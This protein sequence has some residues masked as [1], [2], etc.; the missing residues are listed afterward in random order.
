[1]TP[2]TTKLR[3]AIVFALV[4]GAT[5]IAG[6]G[7]AFAQDTPPAPAQP[8]AQE[9][10]TELD[11]IVVTGTRIESQ[12]V[13]S[14]SPV[15]EIQEEA[16]QY[17]G[18][19]KV[20]E[21]VNQYPQLA[22]TFDSFQNN[23]ATGYATVNLRNLGAARTLTLVNGFRLPPGNFEVRDISIVPASVVKRVDILTGG[24]SAV[25][26]SDAI[27]G[28]VNFI[29][30][31]EFE[32]VSLSAGYSAYQHDNSNDYIQG[33]MDEAGFDYPTGDSG[34]GGI[35]R[36]IDFAIG[37]SFADGAG[38]AMAYA[39]WRKNDPLFQGD[40]DYSAC[41]LSGAGTSCG[42]S[43]TNATGN[44]YVFQQDADGDLI[45][46][47]SG[48]LLPDGSFDTA[49]GAP[50]NFAPINYYQRP[51]ERYTFGSSL[52]YEINEHFTPYLQTMFVNKNSSIQVAES[53][54]FF[55][56]LENQDCANPIFGS[57]CSDLGQ[58]PTLPVNIY[59]A[60]RNIEGGP[61]R[62]DTENNTFRFVGGVKGELGEGWAYNAAYIYGS[63]SDDTQGFNDFVN[64]RIE[65]A[66]LG[67]QDDNTF[68]GC[69][70]Y[71]VFEPGGVTPEQAAALAGVSM[72]KTRTTLKSINA[73][74]TGDTGF[75]MPWV[76]GDNVAVVV[77][78]EWREETFDFTADSISQAGDFAG[79]GGASLPLSGKTNVS[80]IFME[81]AVPLL[82]DV[83]FLNSLDMDLGYRL[84]DYT[85]SGQ[86]NTW[87]VGFNADM[88]MVNFRTSYNHAIRAPSI[89]DLFSTQQLA[90]YTVADPCA[91]PTPDFSPE[92]CLNTGV[93]L[94]AYGTVPQNPAN[95]N[96]QL[97]GGNL[98]L[99]PEVGD[100]F[101][102]G[103]VLTPFENAQFN[104][105]Y[106]DIKITDTISTIGAGTIVQYC[107]LSGDPFLCDKVQRN[108]LSYDL[109]RGQEATSGR[110]VNLTD[111]FG[112]VH[113]NGIDFGARYRWDMLGGRFNTSFNGTWKLDETITPLPGLNEDATFDCTGFINTNCRTHEWRHIASLNY[114]R[115]FFSVNLRWRYFGELDYADENGV[116][117]GDKLLCQAGT[118]GEACLGD[119]G[120]DGYSYIDLSGSAYIGDFTEVT[121]GVNN[122]FDKEPPLVGA[123]NATNANAPGGYDQAGRY[124][125][126]S[127]SFKF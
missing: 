109:F 53:G 112:E 7:V 9:Q 79:S 117:T 50:Y 104:I 39:T 45:N 105:D 85:R 1:M 38:H 43:P 52:E 114:A 29:L 26:G 57:L 20:E 28:V 37:S 15:T 93:P 99:D 97:I 14:S 103:I 101:T 22:P 77:G 81:A 74:V 60:R 49:Y 96:N 80:E 115:D 35:S 66:I 110:V 78:T 27:A 84:S 88:G 55:S 16:F 11:T 116:L 87:K 83:G 51:D 31:N 119:G 36:N 90:L 18:A 125:F 71:M 62:T 70:P 100:T 8:T 98:E 69:I 123:N 91:G 44:F 92:Q 95:Q 33:L 76:D 108:Q 75:S 64:P 94:D 17:A 19:S 61:R 59:V 122:V 82:N 124:I 2:K 72:D 113:T 127:V 41:A 24:A 102:A 25:Y 65:A 63:V 46:G 54:V 42:G 40:R 10:A 56:L 4:V 107:A 6:T 120:I 5:G 12:T 68:D 73:Y 48:G 21:L 3:D 89:G 126:G 86:A 47:T 32:G 23:G 67:C 111:N 118:E 58:D 121:V 30:D 106:Y 34:F 13:T